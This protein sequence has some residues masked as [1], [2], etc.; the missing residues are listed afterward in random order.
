MSTPL[1]APGL[2]GSWVGVLE[3]IERSLAEAVLQA[4]ARDQ[5]LPCLE[6]GTGGAASRFAPE[7][8]TRLDERL[9]ALQ[10]ALD[11]AGLAVAAAEGEV[12]SVGGALNGWL[13]AARAARGRLAGGAGG[14][15]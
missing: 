3:S 15:L 1:T 13:E 4:A 9:A 11:R 6:P 12:A 2:P 7:A 10:Q 8:L 5:Q 14:A